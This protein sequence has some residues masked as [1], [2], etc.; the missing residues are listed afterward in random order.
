M[1]SS[2][3]S[4]AIKPANADV[5]D[6]E[7]VGE[8][9]MK[10]AVVT[11]VV[12][13][14]A[15]VIGATIVFR[16]QN[17]PP[18]NDDVVLTFNKYKQVYDEL[19]DMLQEDRNVEEVASWGVRTSDAA[20]IATPPVPDM[21]V[22]RFKKYLALLSRGQAIALSRSPG[23]DPDIC[24]FVWGAGWAADTNHVALCWRGNYLASDSSPTG[25]PEA[26]GRFIF[27][28]VIERWFIQKEI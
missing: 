15:L 16:E 18:S 13:A 4:G 6:D 17:T 11:S 3:R 26:D 14:V 5:C 20:T 23:N 7:T 12:L 25:P 19:R 9:K 22:D 27:Y 28:P 10:K 24:I 2:L 8:P 21:S 1:T